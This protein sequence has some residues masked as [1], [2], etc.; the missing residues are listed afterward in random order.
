MILQYYYKKKRGIQLIKE[1]DIL[2][3]FDKLRGNLISITIASNLLNI[4]KIFL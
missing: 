3:S 4:I 1:A 2:I